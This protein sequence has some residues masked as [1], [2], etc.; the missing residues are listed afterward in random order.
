MLPA[1]PLLTAAA[2]STNVP[3]LIGIAGL[4]LGGGGLAGVLTALGQRKNYVQTGYQ[5]LTEASAKEAQDERTRAENE[6]ARADRAEY[7]RERWREAYYAVRDE[8]VAQGVS[9]T[10]RPPTDHPSEAP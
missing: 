2:D 9:L 3:L 7:S 5:S 10:T 4:L 1:G 6:R 8:A